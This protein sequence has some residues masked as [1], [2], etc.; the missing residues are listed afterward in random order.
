VREIDGRQF[1][2]PGRMVERLQTLYAERVERDVTGQV[3]L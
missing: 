1:T 3:R 2:C